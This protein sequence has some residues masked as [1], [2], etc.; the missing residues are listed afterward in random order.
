LP[1]KFEAPRPGLKRLF[2]DRSYENIRTWREVAVETKDEILKYSGEMN[3]LFNT[4]RPL[5][6]ER[7]KQKSQE[8]LTVYWDAM[9]ERWVEHMAKDFGVLDKCRAKGIAGLLNVKSVLAHTCIQVSLAYANAYERRTFDTGNSRDIQHV[10]CAS[11]VRTFVTHDRA[12]AKVL[13][14]L[15]IPDFEV[16]ELKTL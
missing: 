14:R 5:T 4:I 16:I 8:A 7:K 11:A 3:A 10:V 12:L 15:P 9:A 1:S 2:F 6:E 13:M